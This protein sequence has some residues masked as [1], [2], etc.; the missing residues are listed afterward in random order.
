MKS[1]FKLFS[2]TSGVHRISEW[3]DGGKKHLQIIYIA[4]INVYL[5]ISEAPLVT[6]NTVVS[7]LLVPTTNR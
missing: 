7:M 6:S 1:N 3:V 5:N 2:L 4:R